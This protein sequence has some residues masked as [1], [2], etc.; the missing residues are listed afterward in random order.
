MHNLKTYLCKEALT[1]CKIDDIN[2]H[3]ALKVVPHTKHKPLH[4]TLAIGVVSDPDI[5]GFGLTLPHLLNI[6]ALKVAV[7]QDLLRTTNISQFSVIIVLV[8]RLLF[9]SRNISRCALFR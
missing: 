5:I 9:S 8:L 7:E 1:L 6:S 4:L 3:S 2:A